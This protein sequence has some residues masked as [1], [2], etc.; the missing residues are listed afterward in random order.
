MVGQRRATGKAHLD[1]DALILHAPARI[2]V[3]RASITEASVVGERLVVRAS[4][5]TYA[6]TLGA[7]AAAWARDIVSPKTRIEKLGVK[8]GARVLLVGVTDE[9]LAGEL[10][11]AGADV[12]R[13]STAKGLDTVF[14]QLDAPAGLAKIPG[15]AGRIA[16]TGAVW[17]LT[18]RGTAGLKD[19]DVIAAARAAGLVDVKQVRFSETHTA[20]KLMV[21]RSAR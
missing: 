15:A 16:P 21:P 19:G 5:E 1:T 11:A 17:V 8:A 3:P 6:L 10:V 12:L 2:V 13:S 18:P 14:L 4:G 9:A 7:K 20:L